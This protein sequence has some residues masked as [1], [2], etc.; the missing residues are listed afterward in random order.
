MK[1]LGLITE[2]NPF[3]NGH[4]YHIEQSKKE[5]GADYCVALMS[6][7]FVQRGAPAI[8]D[9]YLRAAMALKAGVDLVIEMPVS[10]STASAREFA[11]FGVSLFTKLGV[12]D[13]ICFGSECGAIEPIIDTASFLLNESEEYS[14]NLKELVKTGI[15]FP[16]A[17]SMAL[18]LF[19]KDCGEILATP[20]NILGV[21]Y[22]LA[23]LKLDS[24][25]CMATI[26]RAGNSYHDESTGS[27]LGSAFAIRQS[28]LK[29]QPLSALRNMAPDFVYKEMQQ[30]VPLFP[31]DFSMLLNYRIL[32]E[33]RFDDFADMAPELAARLANERL[34]QASFENRIQSLKSRQFTYTRISRAFL[35]LLL[36]MKKEEQEEYKA[37]GYALYARI[38]GFRK[39]SSPLLKR[40]KAH[41]S[42]PLITKLAD[43]RH[44]LPALPLSMLTQEINAS[45]IYQTVGT[46]KGCAFKNEYTQPIIIL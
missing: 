5:T 31:D 8:Y 4:L 18:S 25:L 24:P 13:T 44:I 43:A 36:G 17:R 34:V 46:S 40:L 14:A 11:T 19:Q 27:L 28:L 41:S 23:A 16:Q 26:K 37:A 29:G 45:H 7:S 22:C 9:K 20:N 12:V 1:I 39:E 30:A 42:I 2:Y 33:Q 35:H 38:L 10:F 21:E 15:S 6:G 32:T 3:H